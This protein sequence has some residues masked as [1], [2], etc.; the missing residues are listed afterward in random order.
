MTLRARLYDARGDDR[1]V[2]ISEVDLSNVDDRQLIWIDLD[3]RAET[4]LDAMARALELEVSIVRQMTR[5]RRRPRL[6]RQP[7]R[8]AL[9]LT[10]IEVD[11]E[12]D[13]AVPKGLDLIVGRNLVVTVHDGPLRAID[14]YADQ[15]RDERDLGLLNAG[16][17]MA[18]V[19][20]GVIRGFLREVEAIE[21]AI[22]HLDTIALQS[23]RQRD[24]FFD[25]VVD[26]RRRIAQVR[27]L[28][29]PNRDA[30]MPL[31]RPDFDL[32]DEIGE[33]W[34]G[35]VDRL[36]Q[37]ISAVENARELLVGSFDVY[38]GR[39]AQ[40]SNDVMMTLTLLSSITLPAI[41]LAGVM[42]MNFQIPFFENANNFNIVVGAMVAFS[43][44]IVAVARWRRWI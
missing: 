40:H 17:F 26:L 13:R 30:L 38:L 4:D 32:H 18:G 42:G 1:D 7:D 3:D 2:D 9:T 15:L 19:V 37:A 27:R 28:L 22:D 14:E 20:D 24:D 16:A 8:I 33:A 34:P 21:R 11:D 29:T 44:G 36:E 41:V 39:S 12:G 5:E 23:I 35:I 31:L 43:V 25:E 10:T 6:V